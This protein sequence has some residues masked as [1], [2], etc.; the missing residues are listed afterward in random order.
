MHVDMIIFTSSDKYNLYLLIGT[1]AQLQAC[2]RM[3]SKNLEQQTTTIFLCLLVGNITAR[4]S[5]TSLL[6]LHNKK[7]K[8]GTGPDGNRQLQFSA[9]CGYKFD[10]A[11]ILPKKMRQTTDWVHMAMGLCT[12]SRTYLHGW[13]LQAGTF[14]Y[15]FN[16]HTPCH[17]QTSL[18]VYCS[19]A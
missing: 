5:L 1:Q 19:R 12:V 15:R 9:I 13:R 14:T 18:G 4:C 16:S 17:P 10:S 8:N 11:C 2:R 6:T 7:V 3:T